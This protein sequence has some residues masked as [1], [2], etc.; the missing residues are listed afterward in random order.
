MLNAG[1]LHRAEPYR[2]NVLA[3]RRLAAIGYL[4][5]RVDL[6][7]KGDT[8]PRES[9]TNRESVA[10]DWKFLCEALESQFGPRPLLILGLCSGADNG[11][12]LSALDLRIRGLILLDARSPPDRGFRYRFLMSRVWDWHRWARLSARLLR[13]F[14]L[15]TAAPAGTSSDFNLRDLPQPD[16]LDRCIKNLIENDGR[17]LMFFTRYADDYYNREGQF[18]KSLGVPGLRKICREHYWPDAQHLY[19]VEAHRQRLLSVIEGWA[20]DH[21]THFRRASK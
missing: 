16:D 1:L 11:I 3:A 21:F 12:K 18:V 20:T 2:L 8:P 7:G 6:S 14:C 5:V 19:S 13:H 17:L 10:L 15:G 4:C 9:L